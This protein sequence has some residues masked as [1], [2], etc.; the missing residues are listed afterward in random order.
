MVAVWRITSRSKS[1]FKWIAKI[2]I[3]SR[4]GEALNAK[5][6]KI[7]EQGLISILLQLHNELDAAVAAAYGWP[8]N[9][10]EEEILEK[11]VALNK[12]RAAE[13]ARGLIRWLRPEY[14]NPQGFQQTT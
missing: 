2:Y 8:A 1:C 10:T 6:Q 13:E 5:D 3:H 9:L 12:E 14:Q 7:H 11:L 4:N